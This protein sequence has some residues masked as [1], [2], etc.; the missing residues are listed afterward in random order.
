MGGRG[1]HVPAVNEDAPAVPG[2]RLKHGSSSPPGEVGCM[3]PVWVVMG[4]LTGEHVGAREAPGAAN[5]A[6]AEALLPN[7]EPP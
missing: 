3:N 5:A 2:S 6:G 4:E 1:E 7:I